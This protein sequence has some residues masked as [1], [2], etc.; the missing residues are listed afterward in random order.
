MTLANAARIHDPI[1]HSSALMGLL[2]GAVI[3][4]LVAVAV[5][6]TGGGALLLV[7]AL[8]TGI[9]TGAGIGELLGSLLDR[10]AGAIATGAA[11][12]EVNRLRAAR[13][14][15]DF[16]DC[17]PGKVIATG[18]KTVRVE[19]F[20][21]ARKG[22]RTT[23]DGKIKAGS[24]DTFVGGP[25]AQAAEVSPEVPVW[26]TIGVTAIGLV[27]AGAA[28]RMAAMGTRLIVASRL[29][30]GIA[31]GIGGGAVGNHF[32]G[33]WYGE[34]SKG[35]RILGF[36]GGQIGSTFSGL[37]GAKLVRP[38][39]ASG[40]RGLG[41][42]PYEQRWSKTTWRGDARSPEEIK[43]A[44]GFKGTDPD[45]TISLNDHMYVNRPPSQWVSSSKNDFIAFGYGRAETL[46]Q[47]KSVIY[48]YEIK[49]AGVDANKVGVGNAENHEV[50]YSKGI[51]LEAIKSVR[52][53]DLSTGKTTVVPF[54]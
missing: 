29:G 15:A 3:G 35:Q 42:T 36:V 7:M 40:V 26:L 53:F 8:A 25:S 24:L 20:L 13:A 30:L 19:T 48:V 47:G 44:G 14:K 45:A 21:F 52:M 28:I 12:V 2:A 37:L 5:V 50:A 4:A 16:V 32:G 23:C 49:Q 43:L 31:G 10:E 11:T 17:H 33:K 39:P 18:S 41:D 54:P 34:G 1:S 27:G 38:L 6:G 46:K 22:E 51:S 9:S